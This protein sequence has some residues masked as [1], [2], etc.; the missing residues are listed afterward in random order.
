MGARRT[1]DVPATARRATGD[2][3]A[4][5]RATGKRHRGFRRV[6]GPRVTSGPGGFTWNPVAKRYIAP[7]GQFVG[8]DK[9]RGA[10]DEALRKNGL[11]VRELSNE[12]RS[13]SISLDTW[14]AEMRA[15]VKD[16]NLFSAAA[17]RGGWAQLTPADLG[18]VGAAVQK[19]Y[20]YLDRFVGEI[21]AGAVRLDGAF[22]HR[23][24]S[25]TQS[26]RPL[27]EQ[28]VTDAAIAGGYTEE[29]NVLGIADHCTGLG[30]CVGESARGVVAIGALIP[31][32]S[33]NCR[34]NCRCYIERRKGPGFPWE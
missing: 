4:G 19:Q 17:A 18:R 11:R 7:S 13:G 34:G 21:D 1:A 24:V 5:S 6:T 27:Y 33:R 8:R 26:G 23:A 31:I 16:A 29:R 25:Y 12:L 3:G 2:A 10:L 14:A 9:V 22:L 20:A 15:A 30:S 28:I 32:G